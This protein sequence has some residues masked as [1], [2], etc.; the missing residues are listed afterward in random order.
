MSDL[1]ART[2]GRNWKQRIVS[3]S[4]VW[5]LAKLLRCVSA[6]GESRAYRAASIPDGCVQNAHMFYIKLRDMMT[7][8]R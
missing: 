7:G 2:C 1:Q 3:T 4:N 6:S 8:A 5:R